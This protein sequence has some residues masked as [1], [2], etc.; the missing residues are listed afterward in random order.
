VYAQAQAAAH[1]VEVRLRHFVAA[2]D[3]GEVIGP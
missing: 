1:G 2:P 3:D